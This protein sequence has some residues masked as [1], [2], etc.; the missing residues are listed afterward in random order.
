LQQYLGH[1]LKRCGAILH[2]QA[3]DT[4]DSN[5]RTDTVN[6][7]T[8]IEHN[9]CEL[10]ALAHRMLHEH[11]HNKSRLLPLTNDVMQMSQFLKLKALESF[12]TLKKAADKKDFTAD[13]KHVRVTL[14]V[15]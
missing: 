13:D 12:N 6:I 14:N 7:C 5:A 10:N 3:L 1:S 15:E 8:L 4:D 2:G 9:W 11:H